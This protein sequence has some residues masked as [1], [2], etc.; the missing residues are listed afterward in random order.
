M[1]ERGESRSL[2]IQ[3][4]KDLVLILLWLWLQL[5]CGFDP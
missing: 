4:V 2:A 5:G 1:K 3:W